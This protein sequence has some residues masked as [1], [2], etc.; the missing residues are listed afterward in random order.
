MPRL[1]VSKPKRKE[2]KTKKPTKVKSKKIKKQ[3]PPESSD[4]FDLF[5]DENDDSSTTT[6][7]D[8]EEEEDLINKNEL[9]SVNIEKIQKEIMKDKYNKIC[10]NIIENTKLLTCSKE[11]KKIISKIVYY[12]IKFFLY[13]CSVKKKPILEWLEEFRNKITIR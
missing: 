9:K 12:Y 2:K 7:D 10:N 1:L 11:D 5:N 13:T 4:E 3:L 6:L 8:E